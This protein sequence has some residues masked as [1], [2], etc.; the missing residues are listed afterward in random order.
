MAKCTVSRL[1]QCIKMK[2]HLMTVRICWQILCPSILT[3]IQCTQVLTRSRLG[4]R[5]HSLQSKVDQ[6]ES[7]RKNLLKFQS[8]SIREES[9][10]RVLAPQKEE[11]IPEELMKRWK[12]RRCQQEIRIRGK[13]E[14]KA[15]RILRNSNKCR[16]LVL[17]SRIFWI[18]LLS[19]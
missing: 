9:E 10:C 6:R 18:Y 4:I 2:S 16:F 7:L 14:H 8:Y 1:S 12:S 19:L 3:V 13:L 17:S 11:L 5:E 15:L